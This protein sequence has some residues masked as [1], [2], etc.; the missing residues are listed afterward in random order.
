MKQQVQVGDNR[1]AHALHPERYRA[2]EEGVLEFGASS[3]GD[4]PSRIAETR[5]EYASTGEPVGS[6]PPMPEG[7]SSEEM[8][9]LID[10]LGERLA[11]E[12][13]GTRLYEALL[14]KLD[15]YGSFPGGPE[16]SDLEEIRIEEH[17]HFLMV[18]DI[19]TDLGGDPTAVTPSANLAALTSRGVQDA[20]NDPRVNLL[21]SLEAILIAELVDNAAWDMLAAIAE[22]MG[23]R[24]LAESFQRAHQTEEEHLARVQQWLRNG[25]GVEPR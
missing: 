14:S 5:G 2:M 24:Q 19:I 4:G 13:A 20:L 22:K 8:V 17:Q 1:T 16:R 18:R 7:D 6:L 23:K 10:K 15:A 9:L 11:F 25:H 21:Q 12:R 3:D